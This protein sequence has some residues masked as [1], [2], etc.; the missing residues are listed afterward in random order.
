MSISVYLLEGKNLPIKLAV[1]AC[2]LEHKALL[3]VENR[4]LTNSRY[5]TLKPI[6]RGVV[7]LGDP[8]FG[9]HDQAYFPGGDSVTH[10]S[11]GGNDSVPTDDQPGRIKNVTNPVTAAQVA[12][13]VE[14]TKD[15]VTENW[16][17]VLDDYEGMTALS[18]A[19]MLSSLPG[20][21]GI[22]IRRIGVGTFLVAPE[23]ARKGF[24]VA[25]APAL[26]G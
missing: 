1:V 18:I 10:V 22:N 15:N 16:V 25:L 8:M 6:H 5:T 14:Y 19:E 11:E 9:C 24:A 17:I 2:E 20:A 3:E 23:V 21:A 26:E 4:F 7:L 12:Y 13:A